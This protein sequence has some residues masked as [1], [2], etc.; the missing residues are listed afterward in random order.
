MKRKIPA[1]VVLT[2]SLPRQAMFEGE[3]DSLIPL[4]CQNIMLPPI[5]RA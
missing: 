5:S 1:V 3:Y 2:K 4:S